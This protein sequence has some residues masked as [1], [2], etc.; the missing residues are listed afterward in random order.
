METFGKESRLWT[1]YYDNGQRK[2]EGH[3]VGGKE[4][5]FWVFW[6]RNGQKSGQGCFVNGQYDGA[7]FFW[8]SGG[9]KKK[10]SIGWLIK[11]RNMALL[12]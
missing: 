12:G 3:F 4:S 11:R 5:G 9:Q 2:A 6:F 8:Y 10:N 7:W 1:D